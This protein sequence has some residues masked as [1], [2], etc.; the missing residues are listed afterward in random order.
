[1]PS[2][3]LRSSDRRNMALASYYATRINRVA[4]RFA[5]PKRRGPKPMTPLDK[6]L[7]DARKATAKILA[8]VER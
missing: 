3:S 6:A 8:L 2:L 1:M 4:E 7:R 5:L